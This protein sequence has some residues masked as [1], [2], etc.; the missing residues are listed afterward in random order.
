MAIRFDIGKYNEVRDVYLMYLKG[1]I[2]PSQQQTKLFEKYKS[3]WQNDKEIREAEIEHKREQSRC[4]VGGWSVV[5]LRHDSNKCSRNVKH[6]NIIG[7][8]KNRV[9]YREGCN[10]TIKIEH[11]SNIGNNE[12]PT[13][14]NIEYIPRLLTIAE[15]LKVVTTSDG[16]FI[17]I[18]K[19][20]SFI[21]NTKTLSVIN[22]ILSDLQDIVSSNFISTKTYC[23][24]CKFIN[25]QKEFLEYASLNRKIASKPNSFFCVADQSTA[26]RLLGKIDD[27]Y[28]SKKQKTESIK[29]RSVRAFSGGIP[30]LGKRR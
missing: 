21:K 6:E 24:I 11:T 28:G 18:E 4:N 27:V 17:D 26:G 5:E 14:K 12:E 2:V 1:E 13:K 23:L 10:E 20:K 30:S 3:Y 16:G 25:E 9:T 15:E 29:H 22:M 8:N 19:I 7:C